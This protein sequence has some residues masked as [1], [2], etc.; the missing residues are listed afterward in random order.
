MKSCYIIDMHDKHCGY[1]QY[2]KKRGIEESFYLFP[3]ITLNENSFPNSGNIGTFIC[4][5]NG[6]V[7]E[8]LEMLTA[9][10]S[11]YRI[12]VVLRFHEKKTVFIFKDKK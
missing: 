12:H 11:V 5:N 8:K 3:G 1:C 6:K 7:C 4:I 10:L 9:I 2:S